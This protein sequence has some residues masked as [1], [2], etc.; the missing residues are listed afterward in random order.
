MCDS[1]V[2][3]LMCGRDVEFFLINI[4]KR[5][6]R[7][8]TD[9]EITVQGVWIQNNTRTGMCEQLKRGERWHPCR[10]RRACWKERPAWERH[11]GVRRPLSLE[12]RVNWSNWERAEH[13]DREWAQ[14]GSD[15]KNVLC[16]AF[17]GL[18]K[19]GVCFIFWELWNLFSVMEQHGQSSWELK[20]MTQGR[21]WRVGLGRWACWQNVESNHGLWSLTAGIWILTCV[22]ELWEVT[23]VHALLS[24][25]VSPF[26]NSGNNSSDSV[27]LSSESQHEYS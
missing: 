8:N 26:I 17:S 23:H 22:H 10:E 2:S 3:Y 7:I 5:Y 19:I 12:M 1:C 21:G 9:W 15:R 18:A 6:A 27:G 14:G 11:S 20:T 13:K 24:Y 25:A 16:W 4:F